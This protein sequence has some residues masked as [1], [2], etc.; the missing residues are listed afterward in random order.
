MLLRF[1]FPRDGSLDAPLLTG[2]NLQ[3]ELG[4]EAGDLEL[5]VSLERNEP[6]EVIDPGP[7][8]FVSGGYYRGPSWWWGPW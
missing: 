5:S 6:A 1:P 8:V 3:F 7:H 2:V 4:R